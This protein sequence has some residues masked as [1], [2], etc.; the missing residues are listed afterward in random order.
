MV[1]QRIANPPHV[2]SNP[3]LASDLR[4]KA[5]GAHSGYDRSVTSA[6]PHL[7]LTLLALGALEACRPPPPPPPPPPAPA[8]PAPRR[9][10]RAQI[11]IPRQVTFDPR[12]LGPAGAYITIALV[13]D[14]NVPVELGRLHAQLR[15]RREGV[16]F[17]CDRDVGPSVGVREPAILRPG[18]AFTFHRDLDCQMPVPGHYDVEVDL[19]A[20]EPL[21]LP[22]PAARIEVEVEAAKGSAPKP[23]PGRPGVFVL[24]TGNPVARVP[25]RVGTP[26]E[27]Y[28]VVLA[29]VNAS[30]RPVPLEAG[31]L[32]LTVRDRSMG[33]P[34]PAP[35]CGEQRANVASPGVLA[36]GAVHLART[37]LACLPPREGQYDVVGAL[38]FANE[39]AALDIGA[40]D[41]RVSADPRLFQ[42]VPVP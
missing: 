31:G 4:Q 10:L 5:R 33:A 6:W 39:G 28:S 40:V 36:P 37:Q 32:V 41:V 30:S 35:E 26:P 13:N 1:R 34:R 21:G 38:T 27:P 16:T 42:P 22:Q 12:T 24:L 25:T 8:P 23:L 11:E 20:K 3:I 7:T 15:A 17:T 9:S 2:G 29:F 19:T 14:G 18:R